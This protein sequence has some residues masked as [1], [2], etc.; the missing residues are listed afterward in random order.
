MP[1]AAA[2][3]LS[4]SLLPGLLLAAPPAQR[5]AELRNLLYQDCGSCHGMKLTGGLGPAL[6]RDA[7]RGK[8]REFLAA[9]VREGRAGTPMPPWKQELSD[10]DIAWLVELLLNPEKKP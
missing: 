5:Q 7:L 6:T 10:T 9:T 8:P 2:L 4:L 1:S 3:I